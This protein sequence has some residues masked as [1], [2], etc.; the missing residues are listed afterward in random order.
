MQRLSSNSGFR[1]YQPPGVLNYF[2]L[3]LDVQNP[4]LKD[5][6]VRQAIRLAVDIP[7]IIQANRMPESTRLNAQISQ[8]MGLGYWADAPVYQRDVPKAKQLLAEAG[9]TNL[10]LDI[11][12]P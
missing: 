4:S 9:A 11:A 6:R 7:Q 10:T 2:F 1:T 5:L 3:A 12:T 8:Q